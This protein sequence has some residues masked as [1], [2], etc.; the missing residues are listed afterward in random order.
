MHVGTVASK[1]LHLL[2]AL[3]ILVVSRVDKSQMVLVATIP[4][5]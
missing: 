2:H 5:S 3:A 1:Q 4:E